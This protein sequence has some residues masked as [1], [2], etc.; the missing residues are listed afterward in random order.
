M[1]TT[2][3]HSP[4]VVCTIET[5]Q[6]TARTPK[7]NTSAMQNTLLLLSSNRSE[8]YLKHLGNDSEDSEHVVSGFILMTS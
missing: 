8:L 6:L 3:G 2:K 1:Y 7:N 4:K 5:E